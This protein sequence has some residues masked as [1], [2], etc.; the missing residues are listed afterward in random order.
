[1]ARVEPT[2]IPG[3][4]TLI[5]HTRREIVARSAERVEDWRVTALKTAASALARIASK[6]IALARCERAL[7]VAKRKEINQ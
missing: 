7:H 1:M 3:A 4:A 2:T 6:T 5:V